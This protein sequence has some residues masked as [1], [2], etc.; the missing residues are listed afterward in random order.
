MR[1]TLPLAALL[2]AS[3]AQAGDAPPSGKRGSTMDANND[4]VVTREEAKDYPMLSAK[5]DAADANK[6]GKLDTA[7][8]HAHREAMRGQ[9]RAHGEERW[10]TADTDGD[11]AIS[12]DEAKV[13]MPRLAAE[14]DK[15][16]AN[17]DGKVTREEMRAVRSQRKGRAAPSE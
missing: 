3:F 15:V 13:A 2:V 17:A 11:A 14:F 10:K 4:G 16:D 1:W 9:M 6:D 5:F 12:H 8:M 7:E